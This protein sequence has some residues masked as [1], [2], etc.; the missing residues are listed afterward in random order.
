MSTE[1]LCLPMMAVTQGASS[2]TATVG[3]FRLTEATYRA[4]QSLLRHAHERA[5][6]TI[7]VS[8]MVTETFHRKEYRCEP[9]SLLFKPASEPHGNVYG[10]TGASCIFVEFVEGWSHRLGVRQDVVE[11]V[12]FASPAAGLPL[13]RK[14]FQEVRHPDRATPLALEGLLLEMFAGM[15]RQSDGR[16]RI[17]S[18]AWLQRAVELIHD[19][20]ATPLRVADIAVEVGLHPVSLARGFRQHLGHSPAEYLREVRLQ[21][22]REALIGSSRPVADIA[23]A[24]GFADQSHFTRV[25]T[26]RFG[27]SPSRYRRQSCMEPP[28]R[29]LS[30]RQRDRFNRS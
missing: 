11:R 9:W 1:D 19:T 28:T 24:A 5:A 30:A 15:I 16:R 26:K 10:P 6:V 27:L 2:G 3:D 12:S 14:L 20:F 4:G 22:S 18:P 23:I 13:A 21:W 8:G 17:E 25:F 29:C 7:V